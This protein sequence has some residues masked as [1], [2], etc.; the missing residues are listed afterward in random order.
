HFG[1]GMTED[2]PQSLRILFANINPK[3]CEVKNN[4]NYHFFLL[5]AQPALKT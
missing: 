5:S 4:K 2:K 1:F 3:N